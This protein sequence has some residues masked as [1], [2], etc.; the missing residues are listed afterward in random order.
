MVKSY[1]SLRVLQAS[2]LG[3]VSNITVSM[4]F[5]CEYTS[6]LLLTKVFSVLVLL[7]KPPSYVFLLLRMIACSLHSTI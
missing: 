6:D 2:S 4:T 3:A 7:Q 5:Q 1:W